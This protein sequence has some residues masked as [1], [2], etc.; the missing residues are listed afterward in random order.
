MRSKQFFRL[1]DV[2]HSNKKLV[3]VF[4]FVDQDLK[5]F[6]SQF[7]KEKGVD[8]QIV[9]VCDGMMIVVELMERLLY[10]IF[11]II[12]HEIIIIITIMNNIINTEQ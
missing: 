12:I 4:E 11:Y 9:K 10:L 3:L 7:P 1:H 2:I 8:P 5:K 6:L